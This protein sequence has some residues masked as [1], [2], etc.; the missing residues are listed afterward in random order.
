MK[1][2]K[3]L[4]KIAKKH[5]VEVIY[6][7]DIHMHVQLKGKL[8]VN[9]YP[10]SKKKTA[11][12]NGMKNSIQ[13]V[14][15]EQAVLMANQVPKKKKK[16]TNQKRRNNYTKEKRQLVKKH[17]FCH[18]C[19]CSLTNETG[20]VDHLIPLGLGGLNNM[21]NYVLACEPCNQDRGCEM[22]ELKS[23]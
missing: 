6:R 10:E 19:K 9:Y 4:E 13:H 2:I 7:N 5:N 18:W 17:P 12:I 8:L 15:E 16:S 21:N 14:S 22:P 3:S 20:T 23:K 1:S 11:Y